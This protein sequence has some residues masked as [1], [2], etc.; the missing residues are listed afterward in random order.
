MRASISLRT[1]SREGNVPLKL[2]YK[3]NIYVREIGDSNNLWAAHSCKWDR[4]HRRQTKHRIQ[5]VK[6]LKLPKPQKLHTLNTAS[7]R[8]ELR[9]AP[10]E[11]I[12]LNITASTV[13]DCLH[14]R[15]SWHSYSISHRFHFLPGCKRACIQNNIAVIILPILPNAVCARTQRTA[16][17]AC[18]SHRRDRSGGLMPPAFHACGNASPFCAS[19]RQRKA[20]R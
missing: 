17:A 4:E 13:S 19:Y 6:S 9:T 15:Y 3:D 14:G 10:Q 8:I 20:Y 12:D 11:P 1:V 18:K 5:N 7:T 16:D 2:S